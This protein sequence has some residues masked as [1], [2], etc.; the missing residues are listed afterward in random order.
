ML[1][2]NANWP[3]Y[4]YLQAKISKT[5]WPP[6]LGYSRTQKSC[7]LLV[8]R[9][10][11]HYQNLR[12]ILKL[13]DRLQAYILCFITA[14]SSQTYEDI[15]WRVPAGRGLRW[16]ALAP[17]SD[18]TRTRDPLMFSAPYIV[19]IYKA[20]L[21]VEYFVRYPQC[22]PLWYTNWWVFFYS[23]DNDNIS[24]RK[25]DERKFGHD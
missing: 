16:T 10:D 1:A 5:V 20:T 9:G 17:G 15:Y 18:K 4:G 19:S 24:S 3:K 12:P 6:V 11:E 25:N 22:W 21:W 2:T 7:L 14:I 23:V 8:C 13:E